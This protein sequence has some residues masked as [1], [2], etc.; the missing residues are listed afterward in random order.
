VKKIIPIMFCFNNE[1]AI[2]AAVAFRS[3]LENASKDYFYKLY[4]SHTDI[5]LENQKKLQEVAVY[6]QEHASLEFLLVKN[7]FEDLWKKTKT[8]GH[9][10]KE[11]FYKLIAPSL[12]PQYEKIIISDVDV[13]FLGDVSPSYFSFDPAEDIYV[14]G[15]RGVGKIL[16]ILDDYK[17]DFSQEEI[18]K[19]VI[20]AGYMVYNL[21]KMRKDNLESS[22][23]KCIESNYSRILQLEMDVINLCCYPKIKFLPLKNMM[24]NY[25]YE[26]YNT[27]EDFNNDET[28]SALELREAMENPIQLHYPGYKKPWK[29]DCTKAEEWFNY[30]SKTAFNEQ[31]RLKSPSPR[32][33]I[34]TEGV[35][36]ALESNASV[37]TNGPSTRR[38]AQAAGKAAK[39]LAEI[40]RWIQAPRSA[41]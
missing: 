37:Q 28:F 29:E 23:L 3:L 32:D 6:F 4:V 10:S 38:G 9:Y 5:S 12:F 16:H 2:P 20:G 19:I 31:F 13:V 17:K 8:K 40:R 30:V 33:V 41:N 35:E 7:C 18:R 14:A 21:K 26:L 39:I 34:R 22:F 1:Y 24:C 36:G 27:D 11:A 15:V 25:V